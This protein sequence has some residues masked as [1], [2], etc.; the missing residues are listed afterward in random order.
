M[1]RPSSRTPSSAPASDLPTPPSG[2]RPAERRDRRRQRRQRAARRGTR[3]RCP[4]APRR[5][6]FSA[7]PFATRVLKQ[8]SLVFLLVA[9][10]VLYSTW[11]KTSAVFLTRR[12]PAQ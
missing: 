3:P 10:F 12:Q 1:T 8:Y 2:N 9:S 5:P 6:A 7:L 11:G 4:A